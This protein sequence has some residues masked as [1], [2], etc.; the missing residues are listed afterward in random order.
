MIKQTVIYEA[1]AEDDG[2]IEI[3]PQDAIASAET[4]EKIL[5]SNLI[6]G[7]E[8]A[9]VIKMILEQKDEERYREFK[10]R[11]LNGEE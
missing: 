11:L 5:L 4:M 2:D 10:Q 3:D 8:K 9:E 7:K 6:A 1:E